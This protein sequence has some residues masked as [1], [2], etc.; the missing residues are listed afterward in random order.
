MLRSAVKVMV[1]LDRTVGG[2]FGFGD[3]VFN[4]PVENML[5]AA[6]YAIV[7]VGRDVEDDG[8]A[9]GEV[10]GFVGDEDFAVEMAFDGNHRGE[11]SMDWGE[12]GLF[13]ADGAKNEG[14]ARRGLYGGGDG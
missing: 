12:S 11:Y 14:S 13:H 2:Q 6:W 4:D 1:V 9:A 8:L 5:I 7:G 3:E 10:D